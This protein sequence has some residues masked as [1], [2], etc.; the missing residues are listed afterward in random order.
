[1]SDPERDRRVLV[2]CLR[3][4]EGGHDGEALQALRQAQRML[5]SRQMELAYAVGLALEL[6]SAIDRLWTGMHMEDRIRLCLLECADMGLILAAFP[7]AVL[8]PAL[9]RMVLDGT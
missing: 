6:D 2:A 5:V 8:R 4:A 9:R 1:M 3:L 7:D